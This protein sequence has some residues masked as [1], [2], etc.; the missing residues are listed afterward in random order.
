MKLKK[1]PEPHPNIVTSI[2]PTTFRWLLL[3][4]ILCFSLIWLID[5]SSG[6]IVAFDAIS[7]PI[8]I[9]SFFIIYV[10][11]RTQKVSDEL[12]HLMT[13]IIV[14]G[15]LISSSI[16]HHMAANGLFS[17]AAQWLGLNYVI[18]YLFLEI[19][20]A[21]P[22]TI[23]VFLITLT[24]H[25]IV[26]IPNYPI[27]D[28]L[29]VLLNI[30]VA[31]LVYICLLWTVLK[32]RINSAKSHER[33]DILERYAH[34]DSLTQILNRRGLEQAFQTI[35]QNYQNHQQRYAIMIIDIDH[36]KRINDQYGHLAG[37]QVLTMCVSNLNQLL[38]SE[39]ILGRWGGEEFVVLTTNQPNSQVFAYAEEMRKVINLIQIANT[40]YISAS[41]GIGYSDEAE[42]SIDVFRIA[43]SNLYTAK[44]TGRNKVIDSLAAGILEK[45]MASQESMCQSS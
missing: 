19:K 9:S 29:G 27:S 34:L 25:F 44:H 39:D 22:T 37:D 14:A 2:R 43:D 21:V 16:W 1:Q 24:G 7:Y 10:L 35:E 15:Y 12:L 6:I 13:Y 31:H 40:E 41:I 33:A 3:L 36:F 38:R 30:A 32:M 28:T 45:H 20:K 42:F 8:C 5:A 17:N 18:A 23:I 11:S 4:T 26:L